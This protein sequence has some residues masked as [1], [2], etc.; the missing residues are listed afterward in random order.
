MDPPLKRPRTEQAG[1]GQEGGVALD[2]GS[3]TKA[4]NAVA[5]KPARRMQRE[6]FQ[7]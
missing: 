6:F 3:G 1:K 7:C 5:G 4:Q 2:S